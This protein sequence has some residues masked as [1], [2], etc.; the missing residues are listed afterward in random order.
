MTD[1]QSFT[2]QETV[3]VGASTATNADNI[4]ANAAALTALKAQS[5]T[6]VATAGGGTIATNISVSRVSPAAAVATVI[7]AV[8]TVAGQALTV[9]NEAIAANTVT[10]D[11]AG[12]SNV[13]DGASTIIVGLSAARFVWDTG[14]SLWYRVK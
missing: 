8:G 3:P 11:T 6:A 14:T 10:F 12:T 4:A 2:D 13:A 7:L 5:A 9:V 1:K